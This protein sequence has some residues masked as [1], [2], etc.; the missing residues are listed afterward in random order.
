MVVG[1]N[2]TT[3][4]LSATEVKVATSQYA[5]NFKLQFVPSGHGQA[6]EF[7]PNVSYT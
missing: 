2:T 3:C 6:G 5:S 7:T 1:T 4:L